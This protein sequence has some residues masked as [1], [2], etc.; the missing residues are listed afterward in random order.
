MDSMVYLPISEQYG[1]HEISRWPD[2]SVWRERRHELLAVWRCAIGILYPVRIQ[3]SSNRRFSPVFE[4]QTWS[5]YYWS[6]VLDSRDL[7]KEKGEARALTFYDWK[8]RRHFE[9]AVPTMPRFHCGIYTS[10]Q[11]NTR[12]GYSDKGF[13]F[14]LLVLAFAIRQ[15]LSV[16][17]SVGL[18]NPA[19]VCS[20]IRDNNGRDVYL[21]KEPSP[22][23]ISVMMAR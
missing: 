7:K 12:C 23:L 4:N 13:S 6:C 9:A 18:M 19:D 8:E 15:M 11:E 16:I 14:L 17:S 20:V 1:A 21:V 2:C 3:E 10:E 22:M 5:W